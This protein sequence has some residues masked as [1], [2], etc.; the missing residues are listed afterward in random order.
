MTLRSSVDEPFLT[1]P[2]HA[3]VQDCSGLA[4]KAVQYCFIR[5]E[6]KP[7]MAF[8]LFFFKKKHSNSSELSVISIVHSKVDWLKGEI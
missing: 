6:Q 8:I 7:G 5:N 1:A 4:G 2:Q 3:L